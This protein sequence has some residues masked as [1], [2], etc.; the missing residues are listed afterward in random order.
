MVGLKIYRTR[1]NKTIITIEATA[2]I[3]NLSNR[4]V[5]LTPDFELSVLVNS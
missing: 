2:N 3:A 5:L 1:L 4:L